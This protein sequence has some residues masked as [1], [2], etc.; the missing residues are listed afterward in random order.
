MGEEAIAAIAMGIPA[1][2]MPFAPRMPLGKSATCV[3][4]PKPLPMPLARP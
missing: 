3:V 2:A 4:P 1:P